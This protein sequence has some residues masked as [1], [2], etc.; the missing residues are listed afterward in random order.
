[1]TEEA[2]D[3]VGGSIGD[4]LSENTTGGSK[5]YIPMFKNKDV[6]PV[7]LNGSTPISGV[8]LPAFDLSMSPVD[9]EFKYGYIPYRDKDIKDKTGRPAFNSWYYKFSSYQFFGESYST[10]ISPMRYRKEDPIIAL[11]KLIWTKYSDNEE[12]MKLVKKSKEKGVDWKKN[13]LALPDPTDCWLVNAY[14]PPTYAKKG[15][16]RKASN[17]VLLLKP[18]AFNDLCDILST[19]RPAGLEVPRDPNWAKFM[20]GDVTD[21]RAAL[22]FTTVT[23]MLNTGTS[24]NAT[25]CLSFGDYDFNSDELIYT[26]ATISREQL[27][28]R[29][30]FRTDIY[31]PTL[32]EIVDL[33]VSEGKVPMELIREACDSFADVESPSD[34]ASSDTDVSPETRRRLIR[35]EAASAAVVPKA[36]E[37]PVAPKAPEAPTEIWYAYVNGQVTVKT[38]E[39]IIAIGDPTL[40]VNCNNSSWE[41]ASMQSW[42]RPSAPSAP[43]APPMPSS[44]PKAPQTPSVQEDTPE[45]TSSEET[46]TQEEEIRFNELRTRMTQPGKTSLK[47]D[48]LQEFRRLIGKLPFKG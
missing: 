15:E 48:E 14:C 13:K 40:M 4:E 38:K 8:I 32:Q 12:Y 21:P 25:T 11:R 31:I 7:F 3:I 33:I 27:G 34:K 2:F 45:E 46:R 10:F 9:S 6:R 26:P 20:Y 19:P 23:K 36:P 35:E 28:G 22:K 42:W 44:A 37:A 41:M 1:M 30:N 39:E 43:V 18:T 17:Q 29:I 5:K 47:N 16:E 24:T